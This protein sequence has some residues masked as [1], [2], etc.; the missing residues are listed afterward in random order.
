MTM[1]L[2]KGV[3]VHGKS[4]KK[5]KKL[6]QK[7]LERLT[8]EWRQH[9]KN[10]RRKHMHDLQFDTVEDYIA[11]TRGQ[12]KPKSKK[13]EFVEY[14]APKPNVRNTKEY[15]SLKTS[16]AI[17]ESCAKKESPKYTGDLLVGIGTMHKSNAVP[18]MRGT[19]QAEELAQMRR[20]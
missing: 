6:T 8:T 3:Q 4:K 12:Y 7:D 2:I 16:D 14:E 1:H 9:N 10:M 15:P 20:N 17:P 13:K 11:Y 19:K 18:I 5:A